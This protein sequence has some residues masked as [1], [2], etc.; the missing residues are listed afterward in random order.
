MIR[1]NASLK[2]SILATLVTNGCAINP[3]NEQHIETSVRNEKVIPEINPQIEIAETSDY[4]KL[5]NQT[6]TI[7]FDATKLEIEKNKLLEEFTSQAPE[8]IKIELKLMELDKQLTKLE[9]EF[10]KEYLK[11]GRKSDSSKF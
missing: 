9:S 7:R 10:E 2:L 5:K 1:E 8:V 3:Q 11:I 6:E 4:K